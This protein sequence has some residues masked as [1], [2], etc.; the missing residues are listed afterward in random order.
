MTTYRNLL[1]GVEGET[2]HFPFLITLRD[3]YEN[4]KITIFVLQQWTLKQPH[5][6]SRY[7]DC[8]IVIK[9]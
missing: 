3:F 2:I 4:S 6:S 1:D 5:T 7:R 9:M 8:P